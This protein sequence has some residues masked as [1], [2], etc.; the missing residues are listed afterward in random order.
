MQQL[1]QV[2]SDRLGRSARNK[3][4]FF[5]H[6][7]VLAIRILVSENQNMA[8]MDLPRLVLKK[9]KRFSFT[10]IIVDVGRVIRRVKF[11]TP[12]TAFKVLEWDNIVQEAQNALFWEDRLEE[13]YLNI[14]QNT[15]FVAGAQP[16]FHDDAQ[17]IL[18][19]LPPIQTSYFRLTLYR[20]LLRIELS[21]A[22]YQFENAL[23]LCERT[24]TMLENWSFNTQEAQVL[25]LLQQADC[26]LLMG[27]LSMMEQFRVQHENNFTL[28]SPEWLK[29]QEKRIRLAFK[30]EAYQD[31]LEIYQ[32]TNT[33]KGM[34]HALEP[35]KELWIVFDA[36]LKW[37]QAC[38]I[39]LN[40]PRQDAGT[41]RIGKFLNEVPSLFKDKKGMNV[42][43][44]VIHFLILLSQNKL[45]QIIDGMEALKKYNQRYLYNQEN[46]RLYCFLKM[47][48][49]IPKN[50]F[51]PS[52]I[53]N[54]TKEYYQQLV[55]EDHKYRF[56][57]FEFEI[58]PFE[59]LWELVLGNLSKKLSSIDL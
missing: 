43:I 52:V 14:E 9:A 40:K 58:I 20:M 57:S 21:I 53:K 4:H 47:L 26:I 30:K 1:I 55:S 29:L 12:D 59:L 11:Y 56:I 51:N 23:H 22:A 39:I 41:F 32:C 45:D 19:D 5:C 13:V 16:S 18:Q 54:K 49:E 50:N 34:Q 24:I 46:P 7:L 28:N 36:Y 10:D 33:Q 42:S 31:A 3:A 27:D 44:R 15:R 35:T 37:L 48:I 25:V 38:E 17:R 2:D 8:A 6:Q